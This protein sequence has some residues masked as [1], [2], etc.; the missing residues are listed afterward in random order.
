[1]V[2]SE[3]KNPLESFFEVVLHDVV[4]DLLAGLI[5]TSSVVV[6]HIFEVIDPIGQNLE[7]HS[8]FLFQIFK[9]LVVQ[10]HYL[11]VCKNF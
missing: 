11:V 1:M 10:M 5:Q 2:H 4:H 8:D 3:H 7:D 6:Y 9:L